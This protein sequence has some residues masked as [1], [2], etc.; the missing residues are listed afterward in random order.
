VIPTIRSRSTSLEEV[1]AAVEVVTG[2]MGLAWW[3]MTGIAAGEKDV[4][5]SK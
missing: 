5:S 1:A 3:M 2:R 4:V